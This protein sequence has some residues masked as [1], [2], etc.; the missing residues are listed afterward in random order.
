MTKLSSAAI[1]IPLGAISVGNFKIRQYYNQDALEELGKSLSE[2]GAIYPIIVEQT[3]SGKYDLIVGSR[4]LRAARQLK[5]DKISALVAEGMNGQQ[6]LEL[7]LAENLHR[8]DLTPFE[9]AW[10]IVKLVNDY[11]IGIE[12]LARRIGKDGQFVRRRMQMLSLPREVQDLVSTKRLP[13]SHVDPLMSLTSPDTQV[14]Y[15][16]EAVRHHL[17]SQELATQIKKDLRFAR[18]GSTSRRRPPS[19]LKVRKLSL[20]IDAFASW[21]N[22]ITRDIMTLPSN[23]KKRFGKAV[24]D[25]V[26]TANES[27]EMI[28]T[29]IPLQ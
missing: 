11:K 9:E 7:A 29:G 14:K 20:K 28:R 3:D 19:H 16:R 26:E 27:L 1:E 24:R 6:K 12:Q 15:A 17:S 21:L 2:T 25:L 13:V 5:L 4:R 22:S 8:E 18:N 23:E 10:V